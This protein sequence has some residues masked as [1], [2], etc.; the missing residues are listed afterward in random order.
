MGKQTLNATDANTNMK[1]AERYARATS[2]SHL[3]VK[4][5]TGAADVLIAA[6]WASQDSIGVALTLA[7]MKHS[8]RPIGF[9]GVVTDVNEWFRKEANRRGIRG[10]GKNSKILVEKVVWYWLND[11]CQTCGGRGHPNFEGTPVMK[12][13]E[14]CPA[15]MGYGKAPLERIIP[16]EYRDGAQLILSEIER[17]SND[18]FA[19]MKVY[20][21]N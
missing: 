10:G 1:I 13:D 9:H 12:D 17:I 6:G 11:I 15:C 7:R 4:E 20:L 21:N 16:A 19:K 3:E 8:G 2:S 18:V 14:L 5:S